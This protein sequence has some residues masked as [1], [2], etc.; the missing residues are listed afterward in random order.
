MRTIQGTITSIDSQTIPVGSVIL[1]YVNNKNSQVVGNQ[2]MQKIEKFPI[3]FKCDV[4]NSAFSVEQELFIRVSIE[5]GEKVVFYSDEK[6]FKTTDN[7][8]SI[9]VEVK[10]NNE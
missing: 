2:S 1:I 8:D 10:T 7:L 5:N 6:P 3:D 4:S 9:N